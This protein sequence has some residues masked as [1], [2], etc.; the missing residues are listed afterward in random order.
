MMRKSKKKLSLQYFYAQNTKKRKKR[1]WGKNANNV[2]RQICHQESIET[3]SLF[4]VK[5]VTLEN[6]HSY[7]LE[8]TVRLNSFRQL[9]GPIYEEFQD[10]SD[11][12]RRPLNKD[13]RVRSVNLTN[14]P[15]L[16]R[17]ALFRY[18]MQGQIST[19][20][21][22]ATQLFAAI[23]KHRKA[24]TNSWLMIEMLFKYLRYFLRLD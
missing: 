24:F 7:G 15:C 10:S 8:S 17:L 11:G 13:S 1:C 22:L 21:S 6:S 19:E 18:K 16:T 2:F 9:T 3:S 12:R 4:R 20:K 14:I 23:L 5:V